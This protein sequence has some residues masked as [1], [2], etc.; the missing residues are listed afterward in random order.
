MTKQGT[1]TVDDKGRITIRIQGYPDEVMEID[2]LDSDRLIV[3][4]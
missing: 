3:K 2:A 4:K 1:W